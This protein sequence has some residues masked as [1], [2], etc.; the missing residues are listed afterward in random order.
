MSRSTARTTRPAMRPAALIRPATIAEAA[1][2]VG[3]HPRTIRR[4]IASGDLPA[5]RLGNSQ[6]I[7]VDLADVDAMLRPIPT[8]A[9]GTA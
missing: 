9:T 3:R 2:Y 7:V 4:R 8:A 1:A 6:A 5:Y